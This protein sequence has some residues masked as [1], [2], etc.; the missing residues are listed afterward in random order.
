MLIGSLHLHKAVHYHAHNGPPSLC[1]MPFSRGGINYAQS[2]M[3]GRQVRARR[4]VVAANPTEYEYTEGSIPME[5]DA[6]IRGRRK[7]PPSMEELLKNQ[8]YREQIKL[9]AKELEE[10]DLALQTK[11]YKEGLVAT[12]ARTGAKGHAATTSFGKQE[13]SEN[14]TSTAN[15][16]QPGSWMPT[17]KK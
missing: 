9:K 7:D 10:L 1:S 12:P 16:F 3:M 13:I 14:P 4:M 2:R 11:E 15:R 17:S 6:W 5:W 8:S